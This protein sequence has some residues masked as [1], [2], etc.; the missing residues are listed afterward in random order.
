QITIVDLDENDTYH[1]LCNDVLMGYQVRLNVNANHPRAPTLAISEFQHQS[2]SDL[3]S[4]PPWQPSLLMFPAQAKWIPRDINAEYDLC[5]AFPY[6][7]LT[8]H[9][10]REASI[11][12]ALANVPMF[13]RRWLS[14]IRLNCS[15]GRAENTNHFT[16]YRHLTGAFGLSKNIRALYLYSG[17]MGAILDSTPNN[18]WFHPSL[19]HAANWLKINN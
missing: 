14:P 12:N 17:T 9:P 18:N 6:L 1:D 3:I 19:L 13:H 16:H 8:E 4:F 7:S 5:Q 11:P 2:T 10:T 15:L